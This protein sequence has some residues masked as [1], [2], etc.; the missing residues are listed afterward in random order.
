MA[1]QHRWIAVALLASVLAATT[2]RSTAQPGPTAPDVRPSVAA[3]S[4]DS[5]WSH[6]QVLGADAMEGRGTGSRG[7][8][9][10]A[11]YIASTLRRLGVTPLGG[12]DSFHQPVPM[13]GSRPLAGSRLRLV[14]D[15]RADTLRLADDYVLY[16]TGAK[17]RIAAPAPLVFAGYGIVAPE[18]DYNDYLSIDVNGA[19]AVIV[20]GEPP[21]DDPAFFDADRPT[22]HADSEHKHRV[23]LA[24]G[25]LGTFLLPL[26]RHHPEQ[27]WD[28]WQRTFAFEHVTLLYDIP[29]NLNLV[30]NLGTA[31][32]LF[33]D[34]PYSLDAIRAM[35]RDGTMQS[36]R[37]RVHA[38][39]AGQFDE[40]VFL[41]PNVAGLLEGSD[42]LLR[43]SY[44]LLSAHY[45][46][47][48]IGPPIR[49]DAIYNGVLDN[50]VGCAALLEIA[51]TLS[52]ASRRPASSLVLLFTVGEEKG[53][54]GARHYTAHPLVPLHR[55]IANLNIDGLSSIDAFDDVIGVGAELS[56]LG[57]HLRHVAGDLGLE[58]SPIPDV[59]HDIDAFTRSDQLAFAQA[60]IP[61]ILVMG[62]F[63]FRHISTEQ[64]L[65]AFIQWGAKR[66]H[67]PFDDLTQPLNGDA[68]LQHTMVLLA[69][70]EQL[71]GTYTVPQWLPGSSFSTARLRSI[72]ERR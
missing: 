4:L 48:G 29:R 1:R 14:V 60:G 35:D 22:R 27:S 33:Q 24:Q 21:S 62:G 43:D 51:R 28:D 7:A 67:S 8:E 41:A 57:D 26:E 15:D 10:A 16:S 38:D 65:E 56:T 5:L 47:L 23:A 70:V 71:A 68:M 11:A 54:L 52:P 9:R 19:I 40:R 13:R 64:G 25:A 49:G 42:P 36:F 31:R 12:V 20:S 45:D 53:L 72:A 58:V 55:T 46:H 3:P 34:A 39:F 30:M 44:V 17:T 37:L 69:C 59:F 2:T 50:A 18:Y 32:Q 63:R 6:L 61:S 66:Y